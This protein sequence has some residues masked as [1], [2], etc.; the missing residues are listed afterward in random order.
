MGKF[1]TMLVSIFSVNAPKQTFGFSV[2]QCDLNR[3]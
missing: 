2:A 1:P 3:L